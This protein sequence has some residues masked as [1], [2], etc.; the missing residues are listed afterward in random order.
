MCSH[1]V[2]LLQKVL[3]VLQVRGVL[4]GTSSMGVRGPS[5]GVGAQHSQQEQTQGT[6]DGIELRQTDGQ[7]EIPTD[8]QGERQTNMSH[9]T[10]ENIYC[11]CSLSPGN[12][13][14]EG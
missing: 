10:R 8:R 13:T 12:R 6:Q 9:Q 14:Q 3:D 4:Y 1:F 5:W 11:S 2:P 7:T